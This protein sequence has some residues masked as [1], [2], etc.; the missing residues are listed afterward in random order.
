MQIPQVIEQPAKYCP[1]PVRPVLPDPGTMPLLLDDFLTLAEYAME[2][3]QTVKC[4][5]AE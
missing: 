4:Y 5:E 3:E 2:L 1:A